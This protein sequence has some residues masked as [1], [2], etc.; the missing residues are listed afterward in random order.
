LSLPST[1]TGAAAPAQ[2]TSQGVICGGWA[3]AFEFGWARNIVDE[4]DLVAVPQAL[5][6]LVGA[7][8]IDGELIP[9]I[10]LSRLITPTQTPFAKLNDHRLLVCDQGTEAVGLLFSR[11]PQMLRFEPGDP[12]MARYAPESIRPAVRGLATNERGEGFLDVD[13]P[14]LVGMLASLSGE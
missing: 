2:R 13:G 10:D 5:D 3:L 4:F 7:A 8:N 14:R 9:V 12:A 1:D 11:L 6:W